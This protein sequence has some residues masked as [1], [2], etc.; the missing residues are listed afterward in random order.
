MGVIG[1]GARLGVV[2][3][4]VRKCGA[5]IQV[6]GV[7]DP[8][9][10]GIERARQHNP[11]ARVHEDYRSLVADPAVDWVLIGSWNSQHARH[12]IAALEAGK[13][14][15]CEK[16]LATT[17]EDCH[18]IRDAHRR[19]GRMFAVGFV[20]RYSPH[21]VRLKELLESG[22][23]GK[24]ISLEFNETLGFNHGGYFL[25]DWRRLRANGGPALLE[26]CCH[27]V[28][29][30]QWLLQSQPRRVAS[31]GGLNFFRSE[32]AALAEKLGV[33]AEGRKAYQAWPSTTG[34]DPFTCD[35]DIEDNQVAILEF[36]NETRATFHYNANA[37]ITERRMY[38]L[39][40][41]GA[42]R[43]DVLTGKIE[44]SRIGFDAKIEDHST[45]A[46]GAHG[47]GDEVMAAD[48][49]ASMLDGK[50]PRSGPEEGLKSAVTCLSIDQAMREGRVVDLMPAWSAIGGGRACP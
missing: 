38:L 23:I 33:D 50:P 39:G 13:H 29:L 20:L 31:F 4:L 9:T 45:P 22:A 37:G 42:I 28:D 10:N 35:K 6:R 17:I 16:P 1:F 3:D 30:I 26:K 2:M 47:C 43:A 32:N 25:S 48:L 44:L 49:V 46:S 11:A 18:A 40:E 14:V 27:D 41:K 8:S 15:F 5:P 7:A 19:S 12:A 21:Y 24:V 36:L 34:L